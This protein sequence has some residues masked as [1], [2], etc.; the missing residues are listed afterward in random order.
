MYCIGRTTGYG[1]DVSDKGFAD[2]R[3]SGMTLAEHSLAREPYRDPR[4]VAKIAERNDVKL[5]SCHL[6]F[7]PY[8][9]NDASSPLRE[10]RERC[11]ARCSEEIKR[12]GSVGIGKF[13]LHPGTPFED[14]G[15]RAERLKCAA[16]FAAELAEVAACEGA[17]IAVEDMPHCIGRSIDEIEAIISAND[18]LRVC[19]DVNHLLNNTH[20]EFIDRLGDRIVTVHFSDYDFIDEKHWFPTEGKIDW[21]P[22]VK[23]LYGAGYN[24][25]WIYECGLRDKTYKDFYDTA[26]RIL[27]EAGVAEI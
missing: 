12:G 10:V 14:E 15:E 6:P 19:F 25:P 11:F 3:A 7:K 13:V 21:V 18:K 2:L 1:F 8:N 17:V 24:G 22:L 5:W 23:K 9:M 16:D 20:A 26:A 4:E 27:K